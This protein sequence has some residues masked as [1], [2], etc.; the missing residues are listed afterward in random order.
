MRSVSHPA[1][2]DSKRDAHSPN[3]RPDT[4]PSSQPAGLQLGLFMPNC[5]NMSAISTYRTVPDEWP[6]ESNKRIALA[7]EAAGRNMPSKKTQVIGGAMWAMMSFR[8]LK[9]LS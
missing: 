8:P 9:M 1:P 2:S 4:M 3:P 6:Y 7:A 5:S